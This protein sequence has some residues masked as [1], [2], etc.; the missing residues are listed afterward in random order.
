M[1]IQNVI[2]PNIQL[3]M[4]KYFSGASS[5]AHL[6]C[7]AEVGLMEAYSASDAQVHIVPTK[8]KKKPYT[9]DTWKTPLHQYECNAMMSDG[10]QTYRPAIVQYRLERYGVC[11]P[12]CHD[13]GCQ[14]QT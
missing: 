10:R 5:A 7:A 12:S 3:T 14:S 6:Y 4:R 11:F 8:A 2:H 9:R 13:S 1:F